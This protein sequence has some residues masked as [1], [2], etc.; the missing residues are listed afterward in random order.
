[1]PAG[2]LDDDP[3]ARPIAHIFVDSKAPWNEITDDVPS[4][5]GYP[6]GWPAPDVDRPVPAPASRE[7]A[8]RG[9]CLCGGIIFE[10]SGDFQG[11][12]KCHCSRC[13][14]VV[15]GEPHDGRVFMPA[16]NLDDDPGARPMAHIF[17]DSKAPWNEIT[18]EV[19]SFE[20]FPPGWQ[21]W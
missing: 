7:G 4:F 14:S 18:D 21:G 5:A 9:S 12:V 1:M 3:G 13:G 2:N 8:L 10:V 15:P 11:I 19:P 6:P 17:V 20:G 16:G